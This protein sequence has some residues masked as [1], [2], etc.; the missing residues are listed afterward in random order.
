MGAPCDPVRTGVAWS[1]YESSLMLDRK[2]D[3]QRRLLNTIQRAFWKESCTL[4]ITP[5]S[6]P[7]ASLKDFC[8]SAVKWSLSS[9]SQLPNP[10]PDPS[11]NCSGTGLLSE[12]QSGRLPRK[13]AGSEEGLI[14]CPVI[15][16]CVSL[17]WWFFWCALLQVKSNT[18]RRHTETRSA[19]L[20]CSLGIW[21]QRCGPPLQAPSYTN[22][23]GLCDPGLC[24]GGKES[25]ENPEPILCDQTCLMFNNHIYIYIYTH[26]YM[27]IIRHI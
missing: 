8:F 7:I 12:S 18:A 16:T 20:E 19:H 13:P 27:N 1:A 24:E 9:L 25:F 14:S 22:L 17:P 11:L 23:R 10:F 2:A 21:L 4:A 26:K 6:S 3:R 15:R 5:Q